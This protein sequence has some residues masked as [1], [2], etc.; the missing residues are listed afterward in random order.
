[1]S[2]PSP[3]N[4]PNITELSKLIG[5]LYDGHIEEDPYSAFLAETRRMIDSNFASITMREP[6]GDDGGL[7]FVSCEALAKTFVDDHNN[8]STIPY[9]TSNLLSTLPS[10][11]G[12]SF[13]EFVHYC[14]PVRTV[15]YN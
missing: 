5:F 10:V 7:L 12:L 8:P 15:P 4:Q 6:Q 13:D 9:Y 2:V 14:L 3:I 11:K 1:M